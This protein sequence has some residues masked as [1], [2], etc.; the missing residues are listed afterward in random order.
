MS[1][2]ATTKPRRGSRFAYTRADSTIP[3]D[4]LEEIAATERALAL[5]R[6]AIR[7]KALELR[8]SAAPRKLKPR[9]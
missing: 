3:P 8:A 2:R 1:A 6:K 9:K 5:L 7:A 4:I